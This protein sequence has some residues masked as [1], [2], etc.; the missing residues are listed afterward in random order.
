MKYNQLTVL[1]LY[2]VAEISFIRT[3]T[4]HLQAMLSSK[5]LYIDW[6]LTLLLKYV[7][8]YAMNNISKTRLKGFTQTLGFKTP[9]SI[10]YL[11]YVKT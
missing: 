8:L 7:T 5:H 11:L 2:A 1:Y 10:E 9:V 4:S 6:S 3:S